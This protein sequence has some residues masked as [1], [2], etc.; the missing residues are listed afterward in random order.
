MSGKKLTFKLSFEASHIS[1]PKFGE[2]SFAVCREFPELAI[3]SKLVGFEWKHHYIARIDNVEN[4]MPTLKDALVLILQQK[5]FPANAITEELK[6]YVEE[7][8][9]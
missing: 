9:N 4:E 3:M 1:H 8:L 7:A 5:G 6:K 2:V